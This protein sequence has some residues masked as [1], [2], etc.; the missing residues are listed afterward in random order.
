VVVAQGETITVDDLPEAIRCAAPVFSPS[1]PRAEAD[2][3]QQ[4]LKEL[5]KQYEAEL[6]QQAL[7]QS[8][9]NRGAAAKLVG[10]PVR[11]FAH[12]MSQYGLRVR[13]P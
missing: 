11:T 7:E 10:L 9:Y 2:F 6:I 13:D 12:K 5:V 8:D 4:S 1:P 3:E